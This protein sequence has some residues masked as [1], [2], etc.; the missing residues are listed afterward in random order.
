LP[1]SRFAILQ[2]NQTREFAAAKIC[3][4]G[5]VIGANKR[6]PKRIL[7]NVS[8]DRASK[9]EVIERNKDEWDG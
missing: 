1:I 5:D 7:A 4:D 3:D 9:L 6:L 2:R 8:A